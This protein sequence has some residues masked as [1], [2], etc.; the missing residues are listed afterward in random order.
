MTHEGILG[1]VYQEFG[2]VEMKPLPPV[3]II[4]SF[5]SNLVNEWLFIHPI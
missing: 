3:E 5:S 4:D 2:E 1:D